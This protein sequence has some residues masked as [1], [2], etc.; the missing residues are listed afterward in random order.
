MHVSID[1]YDMTFF[2]YVCKKE[3]IQPRV[4][5]S[6]SMDKTLNGEIHLHK[7]LDLE[8]HGNKMIQDSKNNLVTRNFE[9]DDRSMNYETCGRIAMEYIDRGYEITFLKLG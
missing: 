6:M 2:C 3:V 8:H 1:E 4:V 7:K 5:I 9:I